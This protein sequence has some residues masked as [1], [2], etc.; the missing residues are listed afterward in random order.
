MRLMLRSALF[1]T[2]LTGVAGASPVVQ[3]QTVRI[4]ATTFHD[5]DYVPKI[6]FTIVG[7]PADKITVA[8]TKPDGTPWGVAEPRVD[9]GDDRHV[10][11]VANGMIDPDTLS[12]THTGVIKFTILDGKTKLLDGSFKVDQVAPGK[13]AVDNAWR[14]AGGQIWFDSDQHAD[15]PS[16]QFAAWFQ[17][18]DGNCSDI[19]A[20]LKYNGKPIADKAESFGADTLRTTGDTA[21]GRLV[22]CGFHWD[23]IKPWVNGD[24]GDQAKQWHVLDKHPG[25][26]E[27][28]LARPG[29]P[30]RKLA[31]TVEKS[32]LLAKAGPVEAT[33]KGYRMV[34]GSPTFYGASATDAG[35]KA[36]YAE[37]HSAR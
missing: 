15:N 32:G 19:A 37:R 13:F 24:Y 5:K 1:L 36:M 20:T 28:I 21:P 11:Q 3:R 14:T 10:H 7:D 8:F 16:V 26:Y 29:E 17:G 2:V 6:D 34:I 30:E 18:Y 25:A 23:A 33:R 9:G 12:A 22:Q 35:V 4:E 27:L 31:F